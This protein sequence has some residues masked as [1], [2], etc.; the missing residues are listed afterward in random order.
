ME[1]T[2]QTE[3][4]FPFKLYLRIRPRKN[5]Q[6]ELLD[7]FSLKDEKVMHVAVPEDSLVTRSSGCIW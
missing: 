3:T 1:S 6:T 4:K 5:G 7:F 2:E